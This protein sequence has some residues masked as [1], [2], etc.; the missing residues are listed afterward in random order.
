[1]ATSGFGGSSTLVFYFGPF[2]CFTV[3]EINIVVRSSL[4]SDTSMTSENIDFVFEKVGCAV[5]TWFW[6]T[7]LRF[8]V[9]GFHS[10]SLIRR[11]LPIE[12]GGFQH[13]DIVE[14]E[15]GCIETS[16]NE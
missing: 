2:G 7:N 9:F 4:I 14:T 5:G 15:V 10:G 6:G 12:V 8:G 13:V 11:L 3:I 16:E 1:M